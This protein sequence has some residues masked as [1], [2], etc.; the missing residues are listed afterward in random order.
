MGIQ[1]PG[2][3]PRGYHG[4]GHETLGSDILAV[5]RSL[6]L[7]EMTL[8]KEMAQ[9][10]AGVEKDSWY[11]IATLLEAMEHLDR[12]IGANGLR[13]MGRTL[14]QLTHKSRG[15]P[16][17]ARAVI[18]GI[19]GMYHH[20]N[21]GRDIGGWSVLRF[22]PGLAELEKNTPHHCVMEEGIVHA[23][24]A[25]AGVTSEIAQVEC[26]RRGHDVCVFRVE[27]TV[28]DQRWSG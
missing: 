15:T 25:A 10:L 7:P 18:H 22:E 2:R 19:D 28:T 9:T 26:F 14:F 8:G 4:V 6:Q 11:P 23:A 20:A 24:L 13:Q 12:R 1:R 27:S 21:R 5:V 16:P 17:S 3:R